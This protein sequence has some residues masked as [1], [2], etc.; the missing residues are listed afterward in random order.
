MQ[1]GPGIN[2]RSL[3]RSSAARTCWPSS[4]DIR[5]A[6]ASVR[7]GG[8]RL[9]LGQAVVVPRRPAGGRDVGEAVGRGLGGGQAP[10]LGLQNVGLVGP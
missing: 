4:L 10:Y 7:A 8:K 5:A 9:L 3:N 1:Y 2:R 6:A